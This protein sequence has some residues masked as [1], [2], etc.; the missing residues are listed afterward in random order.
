MVGNDLLKSA[1]LYQMLT[2]GETRPP[3]YHTLGVITWQTHACF[4][5]G[6]FAAVEIRMF[7]ET[8]TG[9]NWKTHGSPQ[10]Y[11][12][13]VTYEC[14]PKQSLIVRRRLLVRFSTHELELLLGVMFVIP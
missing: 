9:I 2:E 6:S 11:R 1:G 5:C 8:Q 13:Q 14:T 4:V 12:I 7:E 10:T 3:S